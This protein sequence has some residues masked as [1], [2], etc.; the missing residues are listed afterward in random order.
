MLLVVGSHMMVSI[1]RQSKPHKNYLNNYLLLTDNMKTI[2]K[3]NL[4]SI[5]NAMLGTFLI[6]IQM[7]LLGVSSKD[8][9]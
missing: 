1:S 3:G 5:P 7:Y 6:R 9:F 4:S 8:T 2:V